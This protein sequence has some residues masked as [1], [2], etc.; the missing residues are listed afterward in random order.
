MSIAAIMSD[1]AKVHADDFYGTTENHGHQ[2]LCATCHEKALWVETK[3]YDAYFRHFP[4]YAGACP[5]SKVTNA[6]VLDTA[7]HAGSGARIVH[8]FTPT[9]YACFKDDMWAETRLKELWKL[10]Y[11]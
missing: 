5:D 3:K 9:Q 7:T 10:K 4:G 11:M 1:G 8:S 6:L 2:F